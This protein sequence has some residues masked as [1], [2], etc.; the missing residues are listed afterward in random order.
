VKTVRVKKDSLQL[1]DA[2]TL[3][4]DRTQLLQ[5]TGL[6]M[7]VCQSREKEKSTVQVCKKDCKL[8]FFRNTENK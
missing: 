7:T 5:V 1:G 6:K 3:L 8:H 2:A 4:Q